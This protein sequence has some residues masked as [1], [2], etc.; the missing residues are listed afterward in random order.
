MTNFGKIR[1]EYI[2]G[3]LGVMNI[4][5]KMKDK[6]KLFGRVERKNNDI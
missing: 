6:L 5:R 3:S 1:N 2:K 4:D